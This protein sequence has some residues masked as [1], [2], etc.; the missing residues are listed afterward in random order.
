MKDLIGIYFHKLIKRLK[1]VRFSRSESS[2]IYKKLYVTNF[3]V[4]K[5]VVELKDKFLLKC[6]KYSKAFL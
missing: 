5:D 3:L 4:C 6:L 2:K 1:C